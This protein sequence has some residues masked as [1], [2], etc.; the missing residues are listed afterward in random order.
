MGTLSLHFV[1]FNH[2]YDGDKIELIHFLIC[3]NI[4]NSTVTLTLL[5]LAL[6]RT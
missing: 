4:S 2:V 6:H 5:S 3:I 1:A